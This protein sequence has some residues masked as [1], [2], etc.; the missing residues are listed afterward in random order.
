MDL[1]DDAPVQRAIDTIIEREGRLDNWANNAGVA[2]R[3][4]AGASLGRPS[5]LGQ[6]WRCHRHRL[7]LRMMAL[8]RNHY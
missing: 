4:P 2:I 8:C 1:T 5:K 3:E 7:L 6:G